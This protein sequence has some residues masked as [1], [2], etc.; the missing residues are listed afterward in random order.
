MMG[1]TEDCLYLNI[2]TKNL[3][4]R[5]NYEQVLKHE[6]DYFKSMT[7][8]NVAICLKGMVSTYAGSRQQ[9]VS[10]P[11]RP[12]IVFL[13]GVENEGQPRSVLLG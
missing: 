8:K 2:F 3:V 4:K 5:N 6:I 1:R 12:V 7:R 11:L 9:A 10:L 13:P